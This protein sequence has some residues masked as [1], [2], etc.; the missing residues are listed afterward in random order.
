MRLRWH[1]FAAAVANETVEFP[2]SDFDRV[3]IEAGKRCGWQSYRGM[4]KESTILRRAK[5]LMERPE[6]VEAVRDRIALTTGFTVVE[7]DQWLVKHIRGE[8]EADHMTAA[9][10]V[11][12]MKMAPSL[13]ALEIYKRSTEPQP[14]KNVNIRQQSL[15]AKVNI[16]DEPPKMIPRTLEPLPS[17][18]KL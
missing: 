6:V 13:K 9:G 11:V 3:L 1:N 2:S 7:A 4:L 17:V 18:D 12:K 5:R 8:V 10:D 15:V 16:G 14:A